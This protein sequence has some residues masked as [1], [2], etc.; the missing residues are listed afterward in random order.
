MISYNFFCH[1]VRGILFYSMN[2][3]AIKEFDDYITA[4]IIMGRLKEENIVCY[5]QNENTITTAP[6]LTPI[7][8]G[9][10]LMVPDAQSARALELLL[11]WEK[12]QAS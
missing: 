8:G 7:L 5:L 10:K 3:V 1:A 11:Q 2:L 9:I 12:E 4:H 6:F